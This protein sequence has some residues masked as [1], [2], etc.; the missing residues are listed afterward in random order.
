M[1]QSILKINESLGKPE[2]LKEV[3][4]VEEVKEE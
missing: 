2:P 4:E 1:L 3:K